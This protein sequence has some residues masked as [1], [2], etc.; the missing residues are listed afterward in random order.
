MRGRLFRGGGVEDDVDADD[1]EGRRCFREAT[2]DR[3]EPVARGIPEP[4]AAGRAVD[5]IDGGLGLALTGDRLLG[6]FPKET[7]PPCFAGTSSPAFLA[8]ISIWISSMVLRSRVIRSGQS[9]RNPSTD[10]P[11]FFRPF[12]FARGCPERMFRAAPRVCSIGDEFPP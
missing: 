7:L 12:T 9:F 10:A 11:F 1:S 4:L 5:G 3:G 8:L 2:V 6:R